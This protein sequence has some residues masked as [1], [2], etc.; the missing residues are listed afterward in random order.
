M[1]LDLRWIGADGTVIR[2]FPDPEGAFEAALAC[3]PAAA[4]PILRALDP[5]AATEVSP[6]SRFTNELRTLRNLQSEPS[7]S[8]HLGRM[9]SIAEAAE[10][11]PGSFLRFIGD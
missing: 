10:L 4:F 11:Q 7:V 2:D 1:G 8:Y 9:A 3:V 6:S 5:Y